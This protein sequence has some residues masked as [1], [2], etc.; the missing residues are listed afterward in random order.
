MRRRNKST[1]RTCWQFD[2]SGLWLVQRLVQHSKHWMEFTFDR[3]WVSRSN[4]A[5]SSAT[6]SAHDTLLQFNW[7]NINNRP[8]NSSS[9]NQNSFACERMIDWGDARRYTRCVNVDQ[10]TEENA[11]LTTWWRKHAIEAHVEHKNDCKQ[12]HLSIFHIY[13]HLAKGVA[14]S[15]RRFF[16]RLHSFFSCSKCGKHAL[17][18]LDKRS[19]FTL[20]AI[21]CT[22]IDDFSISSHWLCRC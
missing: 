14:A 5:L 12:Q 2:A 4:S 21:L 18:A 22:T 15:L 13:V 10:F 19:K 8:H 9:R 7:I 16:S 20:Y 11:W 3:L 6:L 1:W 17:C